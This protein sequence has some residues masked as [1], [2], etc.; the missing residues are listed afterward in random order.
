MRGARV[1]AFAR[2]GAAVRGAR[3]AGEVGARFFGAPLLAA[4]TAFRGALLPLGAGFFFATAFPAERRSGA[5]LFFADRLAAPLPPG[6]GRDE[7]DFRVDFAFAA[8]LPAFRLAMISP[9]GTLTV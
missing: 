3:T 5:A 7:A 1:V 2:R 6:T 4:A 9:F 8:L